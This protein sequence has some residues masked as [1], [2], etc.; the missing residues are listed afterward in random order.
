MSES[1]VCK[2]WYIRD[3]VCGLTK[4]NKTGT[5]KV[6]AISKAQNAKDFSLKKKLEIFEFFFRKCRMVP[7]NV[8]GRTLWALLTYILLQNIKKLERGTLLIL[9]KKFEKKSHNAEKISKGGTLQSRPA[10]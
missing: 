1:E 6:G 7:K 2:K 4:K 3:E 10:L 9:Y 5:S 8:K